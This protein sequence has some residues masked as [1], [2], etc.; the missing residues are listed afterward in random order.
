MPYIRVINL[1]ETPHYDAAN[2]RQILT[3]LKRHFDNANVEDMNQVLSGTAN[4]KKPKLIISFDDGYR[5]NYDIAKPL[6]E[7]FEFTG[8]FFI[9]SK[10]LRDNGE[11]FKDFMSVDEIRQ[12]QK[13]GHIIGCHGHSHIRLTDDLNPAELQREIVQSRSQLSEVLG[14]ETPLFCWIGGEE[15]SYGT[16]AHRLIESAGYKVSFMTNLEV[17]D[18][19]TNPLFI[20]RT[21]IET[22]WPV[23]RVK[24]YLCG[25]MDYVYKP[26]RKRIMKKLTGI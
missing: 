25:L 20:N 13:D 5:N 6:L 17:I 22:D 4:F 23:K 3:F 10:R 9:S 1:H 7:E 16:N 11:E 26:K 21:N 12:L 14:T 2:F 15:W 18:K 19:T 24:F 8:W